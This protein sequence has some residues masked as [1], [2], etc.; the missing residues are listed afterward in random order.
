MSARA[1]ATIR[2]AQS[3]TISRD[4]ALRTLA[5]SNVHGAFDARGAYTG[6][7]Y[8]AQAWIAVNV[9]GSLVDECDASDELGLAEF[10]RVQT[11]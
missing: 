7:D 8:T 6:Y 10:D 3:C 9:D 11:S 1:L 5:Q 4:D 2:D